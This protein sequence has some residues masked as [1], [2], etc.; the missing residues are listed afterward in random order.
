M[1]V[2]CGIFRSA[3]RHGCLYSCGGTRAACEG[4]TKLQ[5]TRLPRS[6][7]KSEIVVILVRADPEPVKM[8]LAFASHG[9]VAT[10]NLD[11]VNAAFLAEP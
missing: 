9:A 5:P 4:L 7:S 3:V 1:R 10:T 2:A 6:R 11:G 8:A